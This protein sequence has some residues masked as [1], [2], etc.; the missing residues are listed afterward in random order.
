MIG[1]LTTP[2]NEQRTLSLADRDLPTPAQIQAEDE[3]ARAQAIRNAD[4]MAEMEQN[5]GSLLSQTIGP[6]AGGANTFLLEGESTVILSARGAFYQVRLASNYGPGVYGIDELNRDQIFRPRS[7]TASPILVT[8]IDF[9]QTDITSQVPCLDNAKVFY[10][11]GQNFGQASI[12]GE[13]LLGPLGDIN[14]DGV[15]QLIDFFWKHRVSRKKTAIAVNVAGNAYFVYLTGLKIG[16]VDP[17]YHIMPFAM[18]GTLL[19]IQRD[20]ANRINVAGTVDIGTT[21][22]SLF[23]GLSKTSTSDTLTMPATTSTRPAGAPG[24]VVAKMSSTEE[25]RIDAQRDKTLL[26]QNA[27]AD[28]FSQMMYNNKNGAHLNQDYGVL[29]DNKLELERAIKYSQALELAAAT[30]PVPISEEVA[31][32]EPDYQKWVHQLEP[33]SH[34]QLP[35]R[36]YRRSILE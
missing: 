3:A 24:T 26:L 11:Y 30:E 28:T 21:G 32:F 15:N 31:K 4:L 12:G 29:S 19:D 34:S 2:E 20:K 23:S 1:P 8:A 36:T 27:E 35:Q 22:S 33:V 14:Y 7:A 13:I 17:E 6:V 25:Q 16:V 18:V 9:N 10:S 5:S